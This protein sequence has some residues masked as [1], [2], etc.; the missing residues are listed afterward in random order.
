MSGLYGFFKG[1]NEMGQAL[2]D[3]RI[4]RARA[5]VLEGELA[6]SQ[7]RRTLLQDAYA[8]KPE[9][10][11]GHGVM[12]ANDPGPATL[13]MQPAPMT[14]QGVVDTGDPYSPNPASFAPAA[15]PAVA[16]PVAPTPAPAPKAKARASDDPVADSFRN[17][18]T[19]LTQKGAPDLAAGVQQQLTQH[20]ANRLSQADNEF[21]LAL[22]PETQ[23]VTRM[24]LEDKAF[25][26]A[27]DMLNNAAKLHALGNESMAVQALNRINER[28]GQAGR[29]LWETGQKVGA[30]SLTQDGRKYAVLDTEGK[31]IVGDNGKPM[32]FG[33]V[34]WARR[35]GIQDGRKLITAK[36]GETVLSQAPDGSVK[37]VFSSDPLTGAEKANFIRQEVNDASKDIDAMFGLTQGLNG[38]M[39]GSVKPGEEQRWSDY[40]ARAQAAIEA[41]VPSRAAVAALNEHYLRDQATGAKYSRAKLPTV[42]QLKSGNVTGAPAAPAPADAT[43]PVAAARKK[44]GF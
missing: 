18:I 43:D 44:F 25:K 8:Y 28:M 11:A 20:I 17:A 22:G 4:S 38:Q 35:A 3:E 42:A 29:P 16:A 23:G 21:K 34:E 39:L 40:K 26:A 12:A 2:A 10:M 31:P 37:P 32:T 41:G 13:P 24:E 6:D 33:V 1:Y 30:I 27:D 5:G 14:A 36:P 15:T 9:A 19:Y 7:R